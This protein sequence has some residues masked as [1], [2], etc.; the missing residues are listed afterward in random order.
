MP[1]RKRWLG[2]VSFGSSF[3]EYIA[4]MTTKPKTKLLQQRTRSLKRA[5]E[6]AIKLFDRL[7]ESSDAQL[8]FLAS[9]LVEVTGRSLP[10]KKQEAK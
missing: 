10:E 3:D 1:E 4:Q 6:I 7:G 9:E 8:C 2:L 5:H